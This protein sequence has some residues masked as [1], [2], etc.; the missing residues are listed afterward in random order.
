MGEKQFSDCRRTREIGGNQSSD[1]WI[2]QE[3]SEDIIL[4]RDMVTA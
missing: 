1:C 3:K 2:E 4:F